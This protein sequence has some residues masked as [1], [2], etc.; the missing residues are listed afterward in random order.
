ML[1]FTKHLT[2]RLRRHATPQ[3]EPTPD[4]IR[5]YDSAGGSA[6]TVDDWTRF[7]RFLLFGSERGTYYIRERT[8]TRENAAAVAACLASDGPRAV[9][10]VVELS[11][12][13]RVPANGALFVLAIAAGTGDDATRAAALAALPA[14]A[15]SDTHLVAWLHYVNAIRGWG[16]AVADADDAGRRGGAWL[17]PATPQV[18]QERI[19]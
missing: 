17:D 4:S 15:R 18:L 7:D 14:V 11:E 12:Q 1:D 10:R 8:L 6:G 2:T 16:R 5:G 9:R 19:G 13:S 3:P